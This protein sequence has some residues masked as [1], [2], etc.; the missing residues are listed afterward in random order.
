MDTRTLDLV[1]LGLTS[2]LLCGVAMAAQHAVATA[3]FAGLIGSITLV[4]VALRKSQ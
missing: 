3:L 2:A 4:A 1:V